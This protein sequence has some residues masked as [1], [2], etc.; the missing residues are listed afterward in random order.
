MRTAV[1]F[2]AY[3]AVPDPWGAT[4]APRR[5][6]A[7]GRV[8]AS[9]IRGRT[10]L[11]LGCGEGHLTSTVFKDAYWI[12][13]VDISATALQRAQRA[14]NATFRLADFMSDD[15]DFWTHE[16]VAA[17]ECLYYLSGTEVDVF[18]DK[19]SRQHTGTFIMS[20]PIIGGKYF[21]HAGL[22]D[23]FERH[24][25][26]LTAWHNLNGYWNAGLGGHL[27]RIAERL[28][29]GHRLL[30]LFP[31]RFIYQRCYIVECGR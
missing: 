10:V 28:P 25:L 27:A 8:M 29:L 21:T 23:A 15:V 24:G 14:P 2:D 6:R 22:I 20:A 1:E 16:T 30:K 3:Y 17:L 9:Y 4:R 11:E 13:A 31:E 7:L 19:L 18:F 26:R 5:D 12:T